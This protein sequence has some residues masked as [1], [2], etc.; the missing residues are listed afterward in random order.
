MIDERVR[1]LFF[2]TLNFLLDLCE[3]ELCIHGMRILLEGSRIPTL[4][5]P[6]TCNHQS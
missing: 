1:E 5:D 6:E 2:W 4:Y 3:R